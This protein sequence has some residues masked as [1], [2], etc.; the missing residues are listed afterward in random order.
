MNLRT[1]TMILIRLYA[2]ATINLLL[3]AF[4]ALAVILTVGLY[5]ENPMAINIVVLGPAH[6]Q[7]AL[8]LSASGFLLALTMIVIVCA[9]LFSTILSNHT[10]YS[11]GIYSLK[12]SKR[13]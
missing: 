7:V 13:S 11:N 2:K 3:I 10:G 5:I 9:E 1:K 4:G 12:N 6:S 8:L